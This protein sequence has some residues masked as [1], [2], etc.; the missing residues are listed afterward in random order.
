MNRLTKLLDLCLKRWPRL[1]MKPKQGIMSATDDLSFIGFQLLYSSVA[2]RH[3]CSFA[4]VD[5]GMRDDQ[6]A[7][8][9]RQKGLMVITPNRSAL[10]F[11]GEDGW[12]KWNK[13]YFIM[14][15]PFQQTLWLDPETIVLDDLTQLFG[16]LEDGPV[17]VNTKEEIDDNDWFFS[18]MP[19]DVKVP[20]SACYPTTAVVGFDA[21]RDFYLLREWMWVVE[22]IVTD[23]K[24]QAASRRLDSAALA[25]GM[26]KH[27]M[28]D[29][30]I[31]SPAW[32]WSAQG[33]A[34][35][36]N[37]VEYASV[38]QL[39]VGV[40]KDF[41]IAHIVNWGWPAPWMGWRNFNL[42]INPHEV[43]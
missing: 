43:V 16:M 15:S 5:I 7:W 23:A 30:A 9:K 26:A 39:L 29:V 1:A 14:Y 41:P 4:V 13:P 42:D 28:M 10:K 21:T 40:K 36:L 18:K 34:N 25:W 12:E 6:L 35:G 32:N 27:E 2:V 19:G 24:L 22:N 33:G 20:W 11:E 31:E 3:N 17:I 8:C 37:F 38:E